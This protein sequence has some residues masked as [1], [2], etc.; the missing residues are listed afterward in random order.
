MSKT[1]LEHS[2]ISPGG[3]AAAVGAADSVAVLSTSAVFMGV[4]P[5]GWWLGKRCLEKRGR[6]LRRPRIGGYWGVPVTWCVCVR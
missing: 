2:V 4:S 6:V 1:G 3:A 5:F